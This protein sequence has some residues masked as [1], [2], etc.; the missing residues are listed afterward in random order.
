MSGIGESVRS[1]TVAFKANHS[2]DDVPSPL[3]RHASIL[4][5][6][7]DI[8][9]ALTARLVLVAIAVGGATCGRIVG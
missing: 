9:H 6:A 4:E 7:R 8:V 1:G 3:A 5:K 2:E